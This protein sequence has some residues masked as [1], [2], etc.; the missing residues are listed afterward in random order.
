MTGAQ[1]VEKETTYGLSP[2][3]LARLLEMGLNKEDDR[4]SGKD[5]STRADVLEKMLTSDLSLDPAVPESLPAVL[6][7]P[8]EELPG[9]TGRTLGQLLLNPQCDLGILRTLKDYGK[10]LSGAS[11]P[12]AEQAAAVV[13]YY[14]AIASALLFHGQRI[15]QHSWGKL[16]DAYAQLNRKSWITAELKELFQ[17]ARVLCQQKMGKST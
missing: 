11:H 5:S 9:A 2:E 3:Q 8:C 13:I 16:R 12:E 15:T 1:R 7:R 4:Q 14:A 6:K 17:K 10:A